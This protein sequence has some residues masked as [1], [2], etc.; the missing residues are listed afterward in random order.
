MARA[1][2]LTIA[3]ALVALAAPVGA[4][5]WDAGWSAGNNGTPFWDQSSDDGS[6]C[7]IGKVVTGVATGALCSN[8]RPNSPTWLPYDNAARPVPYNLQTTV[9]NNFQSFLFASGDY[10]FTQANSMGGD[11][12]GGN[13]A[14]GY[15][16]GAHVM[17]TLSGAAFPI[18]STVS[19]GASWGF[20]IQTDNG[21]FKF[22]DTDSYFALFSSAAAP[23]SGNQI[24]SADGTNFVVGMEDKIGGDSDYNDAVVSFSR[25]STTVPEPSTYVL[26]AS[27]LLGVFGM[28]RRRRA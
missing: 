16:T 10:T 12:A 19:I 17:T 18:S 6:Q 4:Q 5:T 15:F 13:T 27:G 9:G 26:F 22:S 24:N 11:I 7:N 3:A 1:I 21:V 8:D 23:M 25:T 28:A 20:W 2:R 14:W